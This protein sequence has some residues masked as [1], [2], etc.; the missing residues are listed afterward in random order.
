MRKIYTLVFLFFLFFAKAQIISTIAGTGGNGYSGDG[1]LATN[2][3]IYRPTH[4]IA[5]TSGNL[6]IA[7]FQNNRI[8]KVNTSGIISTLAGTGVSG[9]T[10]D[11][12]P[13]TSAKLNG[14]TALAFDSVGNLY[15]AEQYNYCIRKINISTGII[16]TVAGGTGYGFSG[17]GGPATSAKFAYPV[18]LAID[19]HGNMYISDMGNN[20]IRKV[21]ALGV[22]STYVGNGVAGYGGDGGPATSAVIKSP[23]N[24]CLDSVGNLY[25]ADNGN[26][27]I[28]KINLN[29]SIFT[30]AGNGTPASGGG[31]G[32]LAT[33]A[34]VGN[35]FA[36]A[37]DHYGNIYISENLHVRKINSSGIITTLAGTST[38]SN[39]NGDGI[40]AIQ[41]GI[42]P[43]GMWFDKFNNLFV[44]DNN[45]NR[46]RKVTFCAVPISVNYNGLTTICGGVQDTI[47][48]S[49]ASTYTWSTSASNI[50]NDTLFIN[51]SNSV[52]YTL[53]GVSG[54]CIG[55]QTFSVIVN[56]IITIASTNS[57]VCAGSNAT[58]TANGATTYTWSANAASAITNT[59]T[60]NPSGYTVYTVTG[61]SGSCVSSKTY[62]LNV[63]PVP[64]F[65]ITG[66]TSICS[67]T[68]TTLN[69][70]GSFTYT[71][72]AN[73]GG[74]HSASVG[75][76]PSTTTTYSVIVANSYSCTASQSVTV[77]VTVTPT[78][79]I[80][81]NS[82]VCPGNPTTL[83]VTSS[84]G[85]FTWS[86]N[87]GGGSSPTVVVSPMLNTNYNVTG[88]N[89]ICTQTKYFTVNTYTLN[90]AASGLMNLCTGASTTLA[91]TGATSYTWMPGTI[92]SPTISVTPSTNVSYTLIGKDINCIDSQK[93]NITI[94]PCNTP[95][96]CGVYDFSNVKMNGWLGKYSTTNQDL[97]TGYGLLDITGIDSS[98]I[99]SLNHVH[100]VCAPGIDSHIAGLNKVLG[101]GHTSSVRI[102]SDLGPSFLGWKHQT[103]SSSFSVTS[104]SY[105]FSFWYAFVTDGLGHPLYANSTPSNPGEP[106]FLVKFYDASN[107]EIAA[108]RYFMGPMTNSL[109]PYGSSG[110]SLTYQ[111]WTNVSTDLSLYVGQNVKVVFETADCAGGA[112]FGYAYVQIDCPTSTQITQSTGAVCNGVTSM[113]T[114]PAGYI[115][116]NWNGPGI[117]GATNA[118]TAMVNAP[119]NY[120]V[121]VS[122]QSGATYTISTT[123]ASLSNPTITVT[124]S[125]VI[126]TGITGVLTASGAPTYTWSTNAGSA[127]TNTVSV[128]PLV[129]T[130]YT[131]SGVDTNGCTSS[132]TVLIDNCVWPGD[133]DENLIVD[134]TD[135]FPIGIKF[136]KTGSSRIT[137]GNVWQGDPCLIWND[138][139]SNGKNIKYTDC[140]GD[141]TINYDDTLAM[142]LNYGLTHA[143]RSVPQII[144]TLNPDIYLLFDKPQYVPGDTVK[145]DVYIG[146]VSNSQT[147]FYGAAFTLTYD[148]TKV[149][150]GTEKFFFNNS[151]VGNINQS[152]IKF[153]MLN[154]G[155]GTVDASLVRTTHTDTSGSGKVARLQF[156]LKNPLSDC[157]MYF[158]ISNAVK[159]NNSGINSVLNTGMDSVAVVNNTTSIIGANNSKFSSFPNPVNSNLTVSSS[160]ELNTIIIYNSL[161]EIVLQIKSKN[162]Q[163]QIDVSKLQNGVYTI[164]VQG[165]HL[166]FIKE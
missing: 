138:T 29:D 23:N 87:A 117:T 4:A 68:S 74:S 44:A 144:Q 7:D 32:G 55:V 3:W 80:T 82:T 128:S 58:L 100:E 62:T 106:F 139:L 133:A 142:N 10:G 160:T 164:A 31:D 146:S 65:S 50:I 81:G 77:N 121:V 56:P 129:N 113:L 45:N 165:K 130:T 49:G 64:S 114:A 154:T 20:R 135:L 25:V 92:I 22:I 1:G 75:V 79:S 107:N 48:A 24:I 108:A 101:L 155:T 36:V 109:T 11:G 149:Q 46:I 38:S 122:N 132:T 140:N 95:T 125:D 137:Q 37:C 78:V 123:V 150:S 53:T 162:K 94:F 19:K 13:A 112:H 14:P 120:T 8:R 83:T 42:D 52:N 97:T 69:A 145:A 28:R 127:T 51:P 15:V 2:A 161:G 57:I 134:N 159:T 152:K 66:S 119:G 115:T 34:T 116:Y 5:D 147:N 131:V 40:L 96:N 9:Y 105:N 59:V 63:N 61:T 6:Y 72:S 156:I 43:R 12:G 41:A 73:A 33:L 47:V 93:V 18:G 84:P 54:G 70:G 158:T 111:D 71:W 98:G 148:N 110:S 153:S 104:S 88:S 118:Q 91:A 124:G 85:T 17:D 35:T 30:I 141:G 27:R 86:A 102:G 157:E 89:G 67:G 60:V 76:S 163:E 136:G 90:V 16:S 103:L 151:W 39:Y 99:D 143:A 21:N 126:C 26:F 166:T